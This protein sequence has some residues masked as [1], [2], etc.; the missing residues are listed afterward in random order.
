M[1]VM[2][3]PLAVQLYIGNSHGWQPELLECE[4]NSVKSTPVLQ[5]QSLRAKGT[6]EQSTQTAKHDKEL[7]VPLIH[8]VNV[9]VTPLRVHLYSKSTH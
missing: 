9:K 3:I 8:G 2:L 1:K 6:K 4:G 5:V 7:L